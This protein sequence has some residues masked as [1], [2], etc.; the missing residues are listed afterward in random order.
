MKTIQMPRQF[1][2]WL[3]LSLMAVS[4]D[5]FKKDEP[6]PEKVCK[7]L[8]RSD[9][10]VTY[11]YDSKDQLTQ[12][13]G[14]GGTTKFSYD[15]NGYLT[16]R[17]SSD[18]Y[19]V[20]YQYTNGLLSK[21]TYPAGN[22][23]KETSFEYDSQKKLSKQIH[24]YRDGTITRNYNN[25]KEISFIRNE[26]GTITQPFQYENGNVIRITQGDRSYAIY[27][28]DAKGRN[29]KYTRYT[30]TGQTT[31]YGEYTYQDGLYAE[32][33]IPENFFKGFP[34]EI[35]SIAPNGLEKSAIFYER[36]NNILTKTAEL[37]SNYVLN[38]KD[39]VVSRTSTRS[40]LNT[41]GVW[42]TDNPYKLTYAYINCDE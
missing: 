20:K 42:V 4:C 25:G 19:A 12:Y 3:M 1:L 32:N 37:K 2:A 15:K 28:Y 16:E 10:S 9:Y 18:G 8:Y 41:S 30:S 21:I 5:L 7:L 13:T 36:R 29:V 39:Y 17:V 26:S 14:G 33:A 11:E 22:Y 35:K 27:E 38:A 40:Y 6:T 24:A 31:S 23:D 34:E